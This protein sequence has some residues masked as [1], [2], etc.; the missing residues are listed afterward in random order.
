MNGAGEGRWLAASSIHFTGD[1]MI[2]VGVE[3]LNGVIS[4]T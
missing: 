4:D 1:A 2:C 3:R